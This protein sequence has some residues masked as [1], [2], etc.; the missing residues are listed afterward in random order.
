[1]SHLQNVQAFGK[2]MGICTGYG[3]S[4]N[5]GQQ[6]LQVNAMTTLWISAQQALQAV[7]EAQTFYDNA[8]N[9]R[10]LGFKGLRRFSSNVNNILKS[11]VAN[12]LT[13]NDARASVRKIWGT[14]RSQRKVNAE[15]KPE[16]IKSPSTFMYRT[17]YTSLA[18]YFAQLV[19]TVSAEPKY[20]PNEPEYSVEGLKQKLAELQALNEF[21]TQ[22]EISL[23]TARR[24]RNELFYIREDGL[25]HTAMAIKHY[26]RG[27]FGYKS[28]QHLETQRLHFTK[29][30]M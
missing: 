7:N 27:I 8:T 2:L 23:A 13:R 17:N 19:S 18:N 5:P 24:A 10:K 9:N 14:R 4:Y 30:K 25:F 3:G 26:V 20:R 29:P 21:V 16:E 12:E 6:N 15:M 22:A 28:S 1:M 11:C